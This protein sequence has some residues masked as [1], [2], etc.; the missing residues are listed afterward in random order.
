MCFVCCWLGGWGDL[1]SGE[2]DYGGEV[3]GKALLVPNLRYNVSALDGLLVVP[4][5]TQ[6]L[7]DFLLNTK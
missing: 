5:C 2:R 3:W 4:S 7:K 1:R 6:G